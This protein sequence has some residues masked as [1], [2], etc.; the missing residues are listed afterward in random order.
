MS[1]M[2]S[3][4]PLSPSEWGID[5]GYHDALGQWREP[6]PD[7]VESLRAAM[8]TPAD[9][10]LVVLRPGED[11][12]AGRLGP[13]DVALEDGTTFP[14][15]GVIPADLPIGY[16]RHDGPNGRTNLIVSPGRCHLPADLRTWGITAQ[17]YAARST[18][19]WGIGD[20]TDLRT[21]I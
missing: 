2:S 15:D 21:L 5:G 4:D 13:G 6:G 18:A 20:L 9:D 10:P 8:G 17:L 12:P 1:P 3:T 19:S 7:A 16:H 11:G 14:V